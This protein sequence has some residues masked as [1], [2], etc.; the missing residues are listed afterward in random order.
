MFPGQRVA[1]GLKGCGLAQSIEDRGFAV[2]HGLFG[3]WLSAVRQEIQSM[4]QFGCLGSNSTVLVHDRQ[5][6]TVQ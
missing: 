6:S 2:V 5:T 3:G 4:H 1:A